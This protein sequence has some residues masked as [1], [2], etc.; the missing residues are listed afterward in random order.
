MPPPHPSKTEGSFR[1]RCGRSLM[2]QKEQSGPRGLGRLL[3]EVTANGKLPLV[4]CELSHTMMR[5]EPSV[6]LPII[7]HI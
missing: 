6:Y 4:V 2:P 7:A 1:V 3:C 5:T